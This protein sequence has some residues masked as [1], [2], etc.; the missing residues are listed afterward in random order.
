MRNG[1]YSKFAA[2]N[3][4]KNSKTYIPYILTCIITVAMFYIIKSLSLN[5]E[6]DNMI[7]EETI[8]YTLE[9]GSNITAVF[10][11]IFL[12]YTNSFLLKRRKK[13]FG[14]LNILGMEKRHI[15]KVL[16]FESVYVTIISILCGFAIGI[17][18]DKAIY[19][20][21]TKILGADIVFGFYISPK[22]I[23]TTL[24]LFAIIFL[25]IFLNSLR[26]IHLA[27]PI[28]LLKGGNIGEKE[29]KSKW[30]MAVLGV[31]CISV[32]YY[33]AVTSKNPVEAL[34]LFFIAV[35]LVILG[36]YLLFTAGSIAILKILRKNKRYYYK[37]KHFTT[38]SGMIYRMK[39][40]A[41]GLA[42]ICILSTMVLVMVSSTSSLIIGMN[43][44]LETRY[45]Y[46][47]TMY[48][49]L[50]GDKESRE[51]EEIKQFIRD[52]NTEIKNEVE[53]EYIDIWLEKDRNNFSYEPNANMNV[54]LTKS[55]LILLIPLDDYNNIYN[56]NIT[57]EDDEILLYSET[58]DYEYSTL[59]LL[60][61]EYKIKKQL[62]E[63]EILKNGNAA[64]NILDCI[65]IIV[66]DREILKKI[67]K[68]EEENY[69]ENFTKS[70]ITKLYG[71]DLN[72]DNA[73]KQQEVYDKICDFAA[74]KEFEGRVECRAEKRTSFIGLYGGLFFLGTFLGILFVMATILIIYYK[75]ISEG[76]DDKDRFRI[77]QNVGMSHSE[78]KKSI[79]SQI[80]T[81][82]FL[83]LIVAGIH[84]A[85]AFPIVKRILLMLNLTNTNLYI[86]CT[87]G[88]FAVFA[89]LYGI[90]YSLT[91]KTY[92][93]I[94]S[95][96][97]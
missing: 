72:T 19:L 31:I 35:I 36:T 97:N 23:V 21:L 65:Q 40:N 17:L 39:Q 15:A 82:F 42:N 58:E 92:Y 37:T 55:S 44:I 6:I 43:D 41:V 52:S 83:P 84:T 90:I 69:G 73:E 64:A 96:K 60:D 8:R 29:P 70:T 49:E 89:V 4:K 95:R 45:P 67:E 56:T 2:G 28:E 32:G 77:M 9:L 26:Q 11:F 12:F 10:A 5:E 62:K 14:V 30:I 51:I 50:E 66:K 61:T 59:N 81:V 91:A 57:L 86:M 13:E 78:V 22:A 7:G 63:N 68:F 71:F 54:D 85:F 48:S 38:V 24:I 18:L 46:D 74:E 1:F 16:A 76:Y 20:L 47:I 88:C 27:K 94:I 87:I 80:M 75:Q 25:C 34:M 79:H 93:H 3:I 33:I 53:Y